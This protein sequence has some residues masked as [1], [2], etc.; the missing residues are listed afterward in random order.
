MANIVILFLLSL[1]PLLIANRLRWRAPD[2]EQRL[3]LGVYSLILAAILAANGILQGWRGVWGVS[4]LGLAASLAL[5]LGLGLLSIGVEA[6]AS[7]HAMRVP[8][9]APRAR[10]RGHPEP[11][12]MR[13]GSGPGG[14]PGMAPP[15]FRRMVAWDSRLRDLLAIAVLEEALYRHFLIGLLVTLSGSFALSAVSSTVAFGLIHEHFG[16]S[17]VLAKTL[18]G[19]M[20]L[21]ATVWSGSLIAAVIAHLVLN[22]TAFLMNR[23]RRL[24]TASAATP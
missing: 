20:Y 13:M 18:I 12:V 11:S 3:P 15:G 22:T 6:L 19:A 23:D 14:G 21:G 5:G 16:L 17:R 2:L 24:A 4:R 8:R 9:P 10:R 7:W 1:C